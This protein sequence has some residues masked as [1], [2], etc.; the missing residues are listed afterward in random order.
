MVWR[1]FACLLLL[2]GAAAMARAQ[3]P[4]DLP[5]AAP[6]DGASLFANQC[7][8]CHTTQQDAPQRLGP[9]LAGV[10]LRKAG[11]VPAF[12]YSPGFARAGFVWDDAHL[13]T[14]LSTPQELIPGAVMLYRQDDPAIRRRII[15]WLKEQH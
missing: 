6:Q 4:F 11:V 12:H 13:D 9:N 2:T 15:A 5:K 3:M 7:G 10:Y 1:S 8:T 14:W